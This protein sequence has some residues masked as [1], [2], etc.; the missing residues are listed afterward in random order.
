[1]RQFIY[2]FNPTHATLKDPYGRVRASFTL[3]NGTNTLPELESAGF[4]YESQDGARFY[5][6]K[7]SGV[8]EWE[9]CQ[10]GYDF[11]DLTKPPA[12]KALDQALQ[13]KSLDRQSFRDFV[14]VYD[15]NIEKGAEYLL[16]PHF[17]KI[18]RALA[19]TLIT[20]FIKSGF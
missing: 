11:S 16:P 19:F 14:Q 5:I 10:R 17:A 3:Q 8:L 7:G 1:M 4:Y 12:L 13:A 2:P 9:H 6:Y 15:L 20:P 18:D